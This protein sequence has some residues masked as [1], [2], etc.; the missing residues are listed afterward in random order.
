MKEGVAGG[1]ERNGVMELWSYDNSI[2]EVGVA[3]A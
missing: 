1:V 2:V 3:L